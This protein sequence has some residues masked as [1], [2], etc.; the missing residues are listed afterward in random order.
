MVRPEERGYEQICTTTKGKKVTHAVPAIPD[1]LDLE[2]LWMGGR[3]VVIH[4]APGTDDPEPSVTES[5][6]NVG[7]GPKEFRH[8]QLGFL[9]V[10]VEGHMTFSVED[11]IIELHAGRSLFVPRGVRHTY[12]VNGPIPA[13][14]LIMTTPGRAWV[15]YLR[16]IGQPAT[17]AT[18]PPATFEPIP[19]ECV[20]RVATANGLAFVGDRLPGSSRS[21]NE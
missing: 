9:Y 15:D 7:Q 13:R 2:A 12:R 16:A 10:L 4:H 11:E 3:L 18:L 8:H 6:L 5:W 1:I 21:G 20:Q 14:V 19:M 17:S